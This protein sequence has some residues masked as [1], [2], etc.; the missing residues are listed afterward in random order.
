MTTEQIQSALAELVTAMMGKGVV[1]PDAQIWIS[2]QGA[3]T[4][5]LSAGY[6][7]LDGRDYK[8]ISADTDTEALALARAYI[9][10]MP[11]P[12]QAIITR[13]MGLLAAVVEHGREH[14][15]PDEY[16]AASGVSLQ[17][18]TDNLLTVQP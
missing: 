13:H 1:T 11:S 10:A 5:H 8:F 16:W 3:L 15:L 6:D 17:A 18:M 2:A 4:I 9:D 14:S 12:E 7:S